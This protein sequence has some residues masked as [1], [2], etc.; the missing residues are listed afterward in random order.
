[1]GKPIPLI[2][3]HIDRNPLNNKVENFRI[4]CGNCDMQLPTY[5]NKN[6]GYGRK[7]RRT[8]ENIQ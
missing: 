1:M 6:R 5:K 8:N 3:D 4:V 7:Y 2:V